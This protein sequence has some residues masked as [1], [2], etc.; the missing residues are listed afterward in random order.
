M[1]ERNRYPGYDV[2]AKRHSLSWNDATR[3]VMDARLGVPREPRFLRQMEWDTLVAIC[4]R[5]I[6]QPQN[7]PPIPLAAYI[8]Q[9][10]Q[11]DARN[12]FRNAALPPQ[13]EAWKKGLAAFEA[14]A[15]LRYE[16]S[17]HNLKERQQDE[18]L[19]RAE[20][21]QSDASVWSGMDASLFFSEHVMSD[22]I[23]A[24]Y[25]HPTSWN[26]IGFGGPAGPRGYVRMQNGRRDPWEPVEAGPGDE[27]RVRRE[28]QRVR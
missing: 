9:K 13:R 17:F 12:G 15:C 6:P 24:Y 23:A 21:G 22:I 2:M 19:H 7:R 27:T 16:H 18:L 3:K 20:T 26:E 25:A 1:T 28:N 10:L 4:E 14:E 8:D 5:I 11:N